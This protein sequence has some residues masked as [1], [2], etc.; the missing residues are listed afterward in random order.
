ME[1]IL[2]ALNAAPWRNQVV[3]SIEPSALRVSPRQANGVALIFNELATNSVKYAH[4][5]SRPV[6]IR[7]ELVATEGFVTI[8]YRDNGPGFATDVLENK[9]SNIGLKLIRDMVATTLVGTIE[10]ENDDGAKTTIRLQPEKE[11]RT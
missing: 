6:M 7:V 8:C 9:R 5:D 4:L 11:S 10:L 2:A 1:I 3:V